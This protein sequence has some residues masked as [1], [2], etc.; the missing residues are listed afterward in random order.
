MVRSIEFAEITEAHRDV[1]FRIDLQTNVATPPGQLALV[2]FLIK[3]P[4]K[5]IMNI[6]GHPGHPFI[7]LVE[8]LLIENTNRNGG[9]NRHRMPPSSHNTEGKIMEGQNHKCKGRADSVLSPA[10]MILPFMILPS[11]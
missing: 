6:E 8:T 7:D 10:F 3:I 2:E 5:I 4:A 1:H 9:S 11:D